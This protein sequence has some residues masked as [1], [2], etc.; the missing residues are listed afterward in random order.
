MDKW[1][2]DDIADK[3][4]KLYEREKRHDQTVLHDGLEGIATAIYDGLHEIAVALERKN[5]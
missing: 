2:A 4:A 1:A 3:L 5:E